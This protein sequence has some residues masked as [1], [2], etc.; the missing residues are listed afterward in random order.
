MDQHPTIGGAMVPWILVQT[1]LTYFRLFIHLLLCSVIFSNCFAGQSY[2]GSS[3]AGKHPAWDW[4]AVDLQ[5]SQP[6]KQT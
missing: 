5:Y 4:I 2:I 3:R 1:K 6:N